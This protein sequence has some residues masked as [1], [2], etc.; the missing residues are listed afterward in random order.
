VY[1]LNNS[2]Q[3]EREITG[4]SS[5][6]MIKSKDNDFK[7]YHSHSSTDLR[8]FDFSNPSQGS[9][10][11]GNTAKALGMT[12][13]KDNELCIFNEDNKLVKFNPNT[14]LST[15]MNLAVP[16]QPIE[17]RMTAL[18]PDGRIWT[19]GFPVGGN[20]AYDPITGKVEHYAGLTQAE[21][22]TVDGDD[23]YFG[24]YPG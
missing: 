14:G 13:T 11:V 21:S 2:S 17:I 4:T 9:V 1:N 12:W 6:A 18:G 10:K 3:V 16:E 22:V 15:T 23:L 20:G 8:V 19:S 24:N 5:R 7:V